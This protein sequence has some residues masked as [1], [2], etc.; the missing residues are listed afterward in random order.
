MPVLCPTITAV[1][2]RTYREQVARIEPFTKR[3]H[4]DIADGQFAPNTTV[5]AA[6][7]YWPE[8]IT[9]DIH[10]MYTHPRE[11]LETL[12]SLKPNLVVIHAEAAGDLLGMLLELKSLGVK[13][14]VAL[15]P[16]SQPD[17]YKELVSAADHVLLFAGNLGYQGGTANLDVLKKVPDIRALNPIAE[18]AWDGGINLENAPTLV[19]GGIE[20]LNL[21]G[22]IHRAEQPAE[23][24]KALENLLAK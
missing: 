16:P 2:A 19:E 3:L 12:V 1:D 14:G 21:G 4:I 5:G 7:L 13:A 23:A 24:Y 20:V 15:L 8:G 6:Q 17:Q 22:Y 18:L 10:V 11:E 9:A